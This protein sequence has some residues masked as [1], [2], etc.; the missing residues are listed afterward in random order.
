MKKPRTIFTEDFINSLINKRFGSLLIREVYRSNCKSKMLKAKCDCDCG[1][2]MSTTVYLIRKLRISKCMTCAILEGQKKN[3]RNKS[4]NK[5]Y[6]TWCAIINR[7]E[8]KNYPY[9]KYYGAR[10]IT[11][12]KEWRDDFRIFLKDMGEKPTPKHSI[13]RI[14]VN[15]NY[16]P[17]NCRWATSHEQMTNT[18]RAILIDI[19]GQSKSA[20]EW[21]D[22]SGIPSRIILVRYKKFGWRGEKLLTPVGLKKGNKYLNN[23]S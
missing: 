14:D 15:G 5:L 11:I 21:Q 20:Y 12:C 9:Y 13:D 7:C 8:N 3:N 17:S 6:P 18:T 22:I 1:N 2:V 16:E 23:R 4:K 10:G 19:N